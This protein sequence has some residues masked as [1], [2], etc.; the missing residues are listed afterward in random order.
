MAQL[1][2]LVIPSMLSTLADFNPQVRSL[3]ITSEESLFHLLLEKVALYVLGTRVSLDFLRELKQRSLLHHN[4]LME[5]EILEMDSFH[6]GL[7]LSSLLLLQESTRDQHSQLL[8]MSLN[9]RSSRLLNQNLR[10]NRLPNLNLRS[11]RLPNLNLRSNQLPNLN[12]RSNRIPN[13]NSL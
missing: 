6:Q 7:L 5:T 8:E 12:Q 10:S 2:N 13:L 9:Q 3:T 4:S 1:S 11:N